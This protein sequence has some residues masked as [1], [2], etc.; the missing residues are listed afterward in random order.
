MK[1]LQSLE[2][3]FEIS[4]CQDCGNDRFDHDAATIIRC[5]VCRQQY[6]DRKRKQSGLMPDGALLGTPR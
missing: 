4:K 5:T 1:A 3:L 2:T 6:S